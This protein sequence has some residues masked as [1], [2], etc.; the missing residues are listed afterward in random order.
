[1]DETKAVIDFKWERFKRQFKTTL[2]RIKL[3]IIN[4]FR[5][6]NNKAKITKKVKVKNIKRKKIKNM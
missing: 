1:M 6:K 3:F 5:S 4:M 2:T